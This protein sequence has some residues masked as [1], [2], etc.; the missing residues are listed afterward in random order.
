[1]S[2]MACTASNWLLELPAANQKPRFGSRTDFRNGF[3]STAEVRLYNFIT[4][5]YVAVSKA[6]VVNL[7][8]DDLDNNSHKLQTAY[9]DGSCIPKQLEGHQVVKTTLGPSTC[10]MLVALRVTGLLLLTLVW[11]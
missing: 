6:A 4:L 7:L 8:L 9:A 5:F 2:G 11:C 3:C 10:V 1:M